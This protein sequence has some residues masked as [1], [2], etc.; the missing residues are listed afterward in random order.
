M[1]EVTKACISSILELFLMITVKSFETT[2]FISSVKSS[3]FSGIKQILT[4]SLDS[5]RCLGLLEPDL[6]EAN[7]KRLLLLKGLLLGKIPCR[8]GSRYKLVFFF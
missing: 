7:Y 3:L 6:D 2:A 4:T 5:Y 1:A 8:L